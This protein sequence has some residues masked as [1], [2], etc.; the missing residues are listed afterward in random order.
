MIAIDTN[1]LVRLL[2]VDDE[3][4]GRRARHLVEGCRAGEEPVLISLIVLVETEWVLRSRYE[5]DKAAIIAA[6]RRMLEVG[7]FWFEGEAAVEEALFQ[8]Q[9]C[10]CSFVDCLIGAHHRRLGCRTTA[11]FDLKAARLPGFVKT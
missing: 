5:F 7:E 10:P 4:Q 3:T 8:W 9:D 2:V 6:F 11:T 1:V